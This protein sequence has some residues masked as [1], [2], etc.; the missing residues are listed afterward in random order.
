[1]S[2]PTIAPDY[3]FWVVDPDDDDPTDVSDFL[4]WAIDNRWPP[5]GDDLEQ[6]EYDAWWMAKDEEAA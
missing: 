2:N 4:A 1:M 3:P 6:F 5:K